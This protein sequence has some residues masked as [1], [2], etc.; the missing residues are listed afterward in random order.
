MKRQ[1]DNLQDE[2]RKI[3]FKIFESKESNS[4]KEEPFFQTELPLLEKEINKCINELG[5]D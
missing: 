3:P 5:I 4:K 1:I 2:A